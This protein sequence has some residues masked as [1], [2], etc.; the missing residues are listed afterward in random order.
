MRNRVYVAVLA[1]AMAVG[2][3][4]ARASDPVSGASVETLSSNLSARANWEQANPPRYRFVFR[5]QCYCALPNNVLIEVENDQV[6]AVRRLEDGVPVP[7]QQFREYPTIDHLLTEIDNAMRSHPDSLLVEYD[8]V[9]GFPKRVGIDFSYRTADDE[10]DYTIDRV[11][12]L[13]P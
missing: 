9:Q 8:R 1:G 2:A 12:I 11:E 4:I 13:L 10:I 5:R 3:P 7:Q 6:V